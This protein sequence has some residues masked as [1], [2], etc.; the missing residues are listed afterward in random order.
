MSFG[1]YEAVTCVIS[2]LALQG[3]TPLQVIDEIDD[4]SE[5]LNETM[6]VPVKGVHFGCTDRGSQNL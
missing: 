3:N 1:A 6:K 4:I 2:N 5:I